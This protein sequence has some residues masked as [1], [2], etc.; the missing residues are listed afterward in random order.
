MKIH[1]ISLILKAKIGSAYINTNLITVHP[2][3]ERLG[4]LSHFFPYYLDLPPGSP[5]A[6]HL[7]FGFCDGRRTRLYCATKELR[8]DWDNS[9]DVIYQ[10]YEDVAGTWK[11]LTHY[12]ITGGTGLVYEIIHGQ[13]AHPDCF[14]GQ[15][16]ESA[17]FFKQ[18]FTYP[19]AD[20]PALTSG[21]PN[22]T[23]VWKTKIPVVADFRSASDGALPCEGLQ[24]Q[25][26]DDPHPEPKISTAGEYRIIG[27]V[28]TDI[29]DVSIK[30]PLGGIPLAPFQQVINPESTGSSCANWPFTR[31]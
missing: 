16:S 7:G 1:I 22:S 23:T 14:Q 9:A 18:L 13:P 19:A 10:Y 2:N 17:L 12:D 25:D 29:F 15:D 27:F 3:D 28:V 30:G 5:S 6:D 31:S 11:D 26:P 4:D 21:S 20:L 24:I 8:Y